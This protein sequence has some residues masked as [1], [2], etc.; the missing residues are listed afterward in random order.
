MALIPKKNLD[1]L[2]EAQVPPFQLTLPLPFPPLPPFFCLLFLIFS[3]TAQFIPNITPLSTL[4]QLILP[5]TLSIFAQKPQGPNKVL[6]NFDHFSIICLY[7]QF[8]ALQ[9]LT[10]FN[11]PLIQFCVL[12]SVQSLIYLVP[13][14]EL[15]KCSIVDTMIPELCICFHVILSINALFAPNWGDFLHFPL[16]F[17]YFLGISVVLLYFYSVFYLVFLSK[18]SARFEE[19]VPLLML[20][21]NLFL[22]VQS[23]VFIQWP[24]VCLV[25]HSVL[26][27]LVSFKF[28]IFTAAK[29]PL[30]YSQLEIALETFF[31]VQE[32]S[33]RL[34]PRHPTFAVLLF[35]IVTRATTVYLLIRRQLKSLKLR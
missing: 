31:L 26:F 16:F 34:V 33:Y 4:C 7:S 30:A 3:Y 18:A 15:S 20:N 6:Q 8:L 10:V 23:E 19:M 9:V 14:Q 21:L 28:K 17:G 32:L 13:W 22:W 2:L 27:T 12:G 29:I 35:F 24:V 25:I 11:D 5:L 1:Y